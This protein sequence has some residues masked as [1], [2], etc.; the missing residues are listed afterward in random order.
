VD[1]A[2]CGVDRV[3]LVDLGIVT[4]YWV[5]HETKNYWNGFGLA[6]NCN[7]DLGFQVEFDG[8]G[9]IGHCLNT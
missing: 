3:D 1:L 4:V 5:A 2:G 7:L 8:I 9:R 6:C